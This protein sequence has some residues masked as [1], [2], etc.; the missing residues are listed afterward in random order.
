[1]L[2]GKGGSLSAS[3][4]FSADRRIPGAGARR[5]PGASPEWGG[6]AGQPWVPSGR[7]R[8]TLRQAPRDAPWEPRAEA[9]LSGEPRE[10]LARTAD[11]RL[12]LRCLCPRSRVPGGGERGGAGLGEPWPGFPLG[13]PP[14][15]LSPCGRAILTAEFQVPPVTAKD[16]ISFLTCHCLPSSAASVLTCKSCARYLSPLVSG[17]ESLLLM[18]IRHILGNSGD[19]LQ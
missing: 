16:G 17:E 15:V 3:P 13:E 6:Q 5:A 8:C 18:E 2:W 12:S 19:K 7:R 1:M 14:W 10:D 4:S 11:A 9:T